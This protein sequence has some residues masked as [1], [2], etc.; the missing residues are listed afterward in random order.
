MAERILI[1][2]LCVV[3]GL[4]VGA[5]FVKHQ[6]NVDVQNKKQVGAAVKG[7]QDVVF[8]QFVTQYVNN[9]KAIKSQ[10]EAQKKEVPVYVPIQADAACSINS[11]F[12]RLWNSANSGVPISPDPGGADA[13]ASGVELS[14]VVTQHIAEATYTRGVE[15]QLI[16]LQDALSAA[17]AIQDAARQSP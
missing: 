2:I 16:K 14:E 6:W 3:F 5:G 11:G 10:G 8:R 7:G 1:G 15:D 12:V 17:Q 9:A 13:A 4:L